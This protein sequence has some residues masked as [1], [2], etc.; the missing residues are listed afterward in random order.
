VLLPLV[1]AIAA[2]AAACAVLLARSDGAPR[3]PL[4]GRRASHARFGV[5]PAW[6]PRAR[7]PVDRTVTA[8]PAHPWLAIEGDTV[9]VALPSGRVRATAVGPQVPEDGRFPVPRTTPCT[10]VV[11]LAGSSGTVAIA[12]PAFTI[13]DELGR[14]HHPRVTLA[15][16][17]P[18]P[19][20]LT[21][22][23]AVSLRIRGVLPT[24]AGTL[25]WSPAGVRPVVSWDFAVEID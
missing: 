16:G 20:R 7:V 10:F 23:R 14:L 9:I 11:T 8:S 15:G 3:S 18:L 19:A 17:R 4:A 1:I 13:V 2:A 25:R 6:L 12:A 5:V 22:G 21:R 24:G